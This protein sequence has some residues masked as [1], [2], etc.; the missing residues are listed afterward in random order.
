V[1]GRKKDKC[2][3]VKGRRWGKM[4]VMDGIENV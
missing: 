3:V 1:E 2:G 4:G